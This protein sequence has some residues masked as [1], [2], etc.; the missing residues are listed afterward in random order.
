MPRYKGEKDEM[1]DSIMVAVNNLFIFKDTHEQDKPLI[2][3]I[4]EDLQKAINNI[5]KLSND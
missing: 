4:L 1:I 5:E 2:G 3:E